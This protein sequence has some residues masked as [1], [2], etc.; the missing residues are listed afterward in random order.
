MK[1]ILILAM[2]FCASA[3]Y[4]QKT[5][6][7]PAAKPATK[8]VAK[9]ATTIAPVVAPPPVK[10]AA[11]YLYDEMLSATAKVMFIDSLVVP[12]SNFLRHIPLTIT[13]G[14]MRQEAGKISYT[15]EFDTKCIYAN[16]VQVDSVS[17]RHLFMTNRDGQTWTNPLMLSEL[18]SRLTECD[19]PFLLADGITLYFAGKGEGSVGGYDIF[20]T[21]YDTEDFHYLEPVNMGLPFNSKANEYFMAINDQQNLGWLVTDRN[22]PEDTVCI[23]TFEPL[24]KRVNHD[25]DSGEAELLRYAT[26][27]SISDTWGFSNLKAA[28]ERQ[29]ELF[30]I[31]STTTTEKKIYFVVSDDIVYSSTAEFKSYGGAEMYRQIEDNKEHLQQLRQMLET[32]RL[33][34]RSSKNKAKLAESIANNEREIEKF[35]AAIAKNE[36]QLRQAEREANK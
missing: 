26:I 8:T 16:S 7:K 22:Q 35:E 17:E 33:S 21:T 25:P 1:K 24:S 4:A 3:S 31:I 32:A 18:E 30:D 9:P 29:Q 34:Y 14:Q 6:T 2:L 36:K 10:T 27:N 20:K 13:Q 11:D 12:K 28:R 19:Y 23:Y 5:Q 15:N